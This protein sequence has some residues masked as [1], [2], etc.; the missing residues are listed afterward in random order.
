MSKKKNSASACG[1]ASCYIVGPMR[2]QNELMAAYLKEKTG[3]ECSAV[4]DIRQIADG[5][6][7]DK[8]RQKLLFVDCQGKSLKVLLAELR[9]FMDNHRLDNRIVLFNVPVD[10]EFEKEFI[11]KGIHGFFYDRDPLDNFLK[12]V[13]TVIDGQLWLSREM[14]TKCIFEGMDKDH[15]ARHTGNILTQRQVEI[16]ALIAVGSTNDEI[17]DKLCIS[18]HTVKTHLY[19]I[20]KKINVPNRI[21]AALWAAKNL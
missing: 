20:F 12:G 5:E 1:K 16:L 8:D 2:L 15:S 6:P 11:S 13:Q 10:V 17:S 18:P 19:R 21:Q 14:M 4:D 7:K 3:N 9:P